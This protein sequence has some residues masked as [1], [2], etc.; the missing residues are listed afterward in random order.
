MSSRVL[1]IGACSAVTQEFE[2]GLGSVRCTCSMERGRFAA[3]E[4][5]IIRKRRGTSRKVNNAALNNAAWGG[6]RGGQAGRVP[7][8]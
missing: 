7:G 5:T 2:N 4:A 3:L 8:S 1:L 6:F